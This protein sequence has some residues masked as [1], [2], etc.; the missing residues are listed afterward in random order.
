M[1]PFKLQTYCLRTGDKMSLTAHSSNAVK[2][3]DIAAW[4]SFGDFD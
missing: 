1:K 2:D 4:D 3:D